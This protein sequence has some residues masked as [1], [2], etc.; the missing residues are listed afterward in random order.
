MFGNKK[1]TSDKKI[2]KEIKE[3]FN[4]EKDPIDTDYLV[5]MV[6]NP[7]TT[8]QQSKEYALKSLGFSPNDKLNLE[9]LEAFLKNYQNQL[10]ASQ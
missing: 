3:W 8:E 10:I 2:L 9:K 4:L 1:T 7:V 5:K 6:R